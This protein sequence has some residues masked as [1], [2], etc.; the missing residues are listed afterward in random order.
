MPL[1][2]VWKR[3]AHNFTQW[4]EENIDVVNEVIDLDL[5]NVER[6][7][8]A[9]AFSVDLVAEDASGNAVVI[10][11]Q[12]GRSDHDH[13][14]KLITYLTAFDAKAA[15]W[16]VAEPRSSVPPV[17]PCSDSRLRRRHLIP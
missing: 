8:S 12:L 1:R 4:L 11:N 9:G 7:K 15:L 16:I 13:L 6:E 3:E 2:E 10:E 5:A 17:V 14:G